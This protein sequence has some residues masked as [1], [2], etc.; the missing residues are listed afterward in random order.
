MPEPTV[1]RPTVAVVIAIYNF[2]QYLDEAVRSVLAQTYPPAEV[3]VVDDGSTNWT[4]GYVARIKERFPT[5]RSIL[6]AHGGQARAL[7][8]GVRATTSDLVLCLG[9][10][11]RLRPTAVASAVKLLEQ[12]SDAAFAY[13]WAERFGAQ[14]GVLEYEAW[15]P[16]NLLIGNYV[17]PSASVYR[18]S[19]FKKTAGWGEYL[20]GKGGMEDWDF[21]VCAAEVGARG[22][23]DPHVWVEYRRHAGSELDRM[24]RMEAWLRRCMFQRHFWFFLNLAAPRLGEVYV[25][26]T[27][28][29]GKIMKQ[30]AQ[31]SARVEALRRD[32]ATTTQAILSR[33]AQQVPHA[34]AIAAEQRRLSA[35]EQQLRGIQ[36]SK[37]FRA[38]RPL[39]PLI[40]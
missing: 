12:H 11:D 5:V 2:G 9:A 19:L 33:R 3:L 8:L 32:I 23:R 14:S 7:N 6:A 30:V 1:R 36:R 17:Q 4:R 16:M 31:A 28:S 26:N 18:R 24:N 27:T 10:D 15:D 34:A 37:A 38:L 21:V 25:A 20:R 29:N 22:V 39:A 35:L 40:R 13:G